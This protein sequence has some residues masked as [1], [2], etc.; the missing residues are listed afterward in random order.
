MGHMDVACHHDN[1]EL[2]RDFGGSGVFRDGGDDL[3]RVV[4]IY[5]YIYEI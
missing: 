4:Y 1:G 3:V 2:Q 5:I